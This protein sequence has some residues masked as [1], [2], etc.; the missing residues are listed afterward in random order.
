MAK[1]SAKAIAAIRAGRLTEVAKRNDANNAAARRK[2][3]NIDRRRGHGDAG[4]AR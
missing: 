1:L 3:Q 4:T 2:V